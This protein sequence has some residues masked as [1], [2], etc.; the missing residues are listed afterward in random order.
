LPALE[1]D[2]YTL[3]IMRKAND[4]LLYRGL[5]G[6]PGGSIIRALQ[7]KHLIDYGYLEFIYDWDKDRA[8]LRIT[9]LGRSRYDQEICRNLHVIA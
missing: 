3:K 4:G 8:A 7:I 1:L 5:F 9:A 2:Q 6:W